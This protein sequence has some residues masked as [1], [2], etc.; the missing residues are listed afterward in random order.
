MGSGYC[1][2]IIIDLFIHIHVQQRCVYAMRLQGML[3]NVWYCVLNIKIIL[4]YLCDGRNWRFK[5]FSK[6]LPSIKPGWKYRKLSIHSTKK[7]VSHGKTRTTNREKWLY[8][9]LKHAGVK[10]V[11]IIQVKCLHVR[12]AWNAINNQSISKAISQ[13]KNLWRLWVNWRMYLF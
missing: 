11:V 4:N 1:A 5:V 12:C 9:L 3:K 2:V 13:L 7:F 10:F 8:G 6:V